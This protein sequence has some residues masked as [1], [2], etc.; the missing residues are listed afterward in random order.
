MMQAFA[1]HAQV[2]SRREDVICNASLALSSDSKIYC[3]WRY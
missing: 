3:H 1:A 2:I